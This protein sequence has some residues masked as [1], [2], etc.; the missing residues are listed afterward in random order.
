MVVGVVRRRRSRKTED[1]G[2]LAGRKGKVRG[3]VY[4]ILY[5]ISCKA[6]DVCG[7]QGIKVL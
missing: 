1:G 4:I 3:V 6:G 2:P 7:G 5:S